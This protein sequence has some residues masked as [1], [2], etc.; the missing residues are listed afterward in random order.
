MSTVAPVPSDSAEVSSGPVPGD[1]P[2]R[3]SDL[4]AA[5]WIKMRSLPST[6]WGLLVT[7][8][9]VVGAAVGAALADYRNYPG[10]SPDIQQQH[11][12]SM[13]DSFSISGAYI[14][15][16]AAVSMGA[17]VVV[18]EYSSGLIRT[19]TVAV[20]ARAQVLLAKA[21]VVA[22]VWTVVG[23]VLS[24]LSFYVVQAILS[25][26]HAS[27]GIT[28]PGA[29]RS[30]LVT[31]LLPPVCALLGLGLGVLIRHS[32]TTVVTGVFLL[33]LLP[34]FFSLNQAWSAAMEHMTVISAWR[35]LTRMWGNP[36]GKTQQL[37]GS[38]PESWTVYAAWPLIALALALLVV[39]RRDV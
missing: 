2:A 30:L 16:L 31:A 36:T 20:P 17:I 15:M 22:A 7:A 33:L 12:F 34:T 18:S 13:G 11:P 37:Y 9:G 14:V 35:T 6:L 19:T 32:A 21:V 29:P 1:T 10:Y 28:H 39:R 26:R 23:A 5:E 3:F 24:V 8:L 38:I 27:I 25:G 4:L